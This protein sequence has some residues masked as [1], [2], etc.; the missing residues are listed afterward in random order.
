MK[1][2]GFLVFIF[3]LIVG[4]AVAGFFTLG[5][6]TA[7]VFNFKFDFAGVRGSGNIGTENR[8][9]S[10]FKG[11]DVSGVFQVEIVAQKDFG[12]Q[13]ETD[14][15]LLEYVKTE[16]DD[17]I[18]E[19]STTK[20]IK[21]TNGLKIRISAPDIEKIEASGATKISLADLKNT[22]LN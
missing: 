6:S 15:N 16:V 1:K 20:R 11:I 7:E 14:D 19:I 3:A 4:V 12:V 5:R 13:I 18:L 2:I 17:G 22:S 10:G 8:N 21:S 9:I